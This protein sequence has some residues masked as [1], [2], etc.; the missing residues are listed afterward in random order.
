MSKSLEDSSNATDTSSQTISNAI[1]WM[2]DREYSIIARNKAEPSLRSRSEK[3]DDANM[4]TL[5][6]RDKEELRQH[7][8][9]IVST[10]VPSNSELQYYMK[11]KSLMNQSKSCDSTTKQIVPHAEMSVPSNSFYRIVAY[12]F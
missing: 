4:V 6:E 3:I 10:A 5:T 7:T 1:D 9:F 8:E 2:I 11:I 12:S